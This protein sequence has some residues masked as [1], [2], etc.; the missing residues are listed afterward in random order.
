MDRVYTF[1]Y[2][3][4]QMHRIDLPSFSAESLLP[5]LL[6]SKGII[7][8]P[9][10]EPTAKPLN[11]QWDYRPDSQFGVNAFSRYP[12]QACGTSSILALL[13]DDNPVMPSICPTFSRG[14]V[15]ATCLEFPL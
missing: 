12:P 15:V 11:L 5:T 14:A 8:N 9:C 1:N 13:L 7:L 10:I 2:H 6:E 4:A 3:P